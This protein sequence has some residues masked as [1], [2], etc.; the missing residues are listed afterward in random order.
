MSCTCPTCSA[1]RRLRRQWWAL[2]IILLGLGLVVGWMVVER[3]W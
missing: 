3:W 2:A 1:D